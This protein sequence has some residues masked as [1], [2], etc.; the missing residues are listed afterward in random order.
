MILPLALLLMSQ[1]QKATIFDKV[2]PVDASKVVRMP[3]DIPNPRTS[4]NLTFSVEEKNGKV[5]VILRKAPN[6]DILGQTDFESDGSIKASLTEPSKIWVDVDNRAR[7]LS[8]ASVDMTIKASWKAE[9]PVEAREL[10]QST[11]KKV[12]AASLSLFALIAGFSAWRL[13]PLW[14]S[15]AS[16]LR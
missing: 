1:I 3:F 11:R 6:G 14:R 9:L 4:L 10:P 7:R 15:R 8:H 13:I 2:V 5:K 12:V 16:F